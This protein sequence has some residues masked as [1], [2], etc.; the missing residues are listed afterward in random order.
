MVAQTRAGLW[1]R[2]GSV[3][4][5]AMNKANEPTLVKFETAMLPLVRQYMEDSADSGKKKSKKRKISAGAKKVVPVINIDFSDDEE[6]DF[7][8]LGDTDEV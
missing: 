7:D 6:L 4:Q 3:F 5:E 2:F 8:E 1:K